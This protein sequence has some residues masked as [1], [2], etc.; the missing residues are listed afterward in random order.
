MSFLKDNPDVFQT[1]ENQLYEIISPSE[2]KKETNGK[3]LKKDKKEEET[4]WFW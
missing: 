3:T 2:S 1:I 4:V